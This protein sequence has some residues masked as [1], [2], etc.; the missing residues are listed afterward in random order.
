MIPLFLIGG[1]WRAETFPRT[2]GRF[3]RAAVKNDRRKIAFVVAEEPETDAQTQFLR[4][5]KPFE[6]IGLAFSETAG[7]IVS[8]ENPLTEEK[9][10]ET[11]PTGVF[12]CGG[13]TPAYANALCTDRNWLAFLKEKEIPYGGFS[14]GAAIAAERAIVGGWRR[15]I[16]EKS[17][18]IVN[19]NAGEDLDYLEVRKGLRLV[20]FAVDIHASQWGTLS[21]LIHAVDAETVNEGWAIDENTLMEI[22]EGE[23][24]IY[25]DGSA[26]RVSQ[27]NGKISVEIVNEQFA[28]FETPFVN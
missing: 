2:Y 18:E 22:I 6:H 28:R 17:V 11:E 5:F 27:K 21:R 1:G 8:A 9:L 16:R 3:L 10:A 26:Y 25:G 19:E 4:F 20:P 7:I 23:V 24:K 14:A 12:V 13:L 15:K